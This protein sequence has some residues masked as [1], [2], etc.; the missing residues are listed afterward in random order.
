M[1]ADSGRAVMRAR[2]R[3]AY[4][5]RLLAR[6]HSWP[7]ARKS[8]NAASYRPTN[9][10]LQ[11]ITVKRNSG[12][13]SILHWCAQIRGALSCAQGHGAHMRVDCWRACILGHLRANHGRAASYRPTNH[14]LQSI[15]VKKLWNTK[16]LTLMRADSGRAVMR[17]RSRR[18]YARRVLVRMHSWPPARKSRARRKLQTH[19]PTTTYRVWLWRNSGTQSILH[20]CAQIRGALSCAQGHGAH[21]RVDLLARMHSWPPAR[22]SWA[23]C[24]LQTHQPQLTEYDCEETLE[25]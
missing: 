23:R 20:S 11:S 21:M 3:R 9:H 17:A 2:S 16:Y 19:A 14:N 22:K 10:N 1:R 4:A 13:Q 12:A 8:Q 18:A 7:P 24:K 6:M 25:H 15:S 5:R